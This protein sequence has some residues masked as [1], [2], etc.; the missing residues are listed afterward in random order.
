MLNSYKKMARLNCFLNIQSTWLVSVR[1]LGKLAF[2]EIE[3]LRIS[4]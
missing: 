1:L 4:R 3:L 2:I